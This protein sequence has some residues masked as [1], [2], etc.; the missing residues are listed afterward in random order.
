MSEK[1]F[2][3]FS[4]SFW[5]P[6]DP[7]W[8]GV[9]PNLGKTRQCTQYFQMLRTNVCL[10]VARIFRKPGLILLF[11]TVVCFAYVHEEPLLKTGNY[12]HI[13]K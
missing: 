10:K 4:P 2:E 6:P 13:A 11:S 5:G 3:F 9:S 8:V 12:N 1:A 7:G